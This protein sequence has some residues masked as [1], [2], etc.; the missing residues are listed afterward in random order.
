MGE[1]GGE[2]RKDRTCAA[3]YQL[4]NY[5]PFGEG[6]ELRTNSSGANTYQFVY[7]LR[8]QNYVLTPETRYI[9]DR[10]LRVEDRPRA[11]HSVGTW[12]A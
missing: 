12:H 3:T 8:L 10:R 11:M 7:D 9:E 2:L 6:G 5:L 4:A 1:W